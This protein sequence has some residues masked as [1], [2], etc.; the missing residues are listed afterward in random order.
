MC[1]YFKNSNLWR[2]CTLRHFSNL[3]QFGPIFYKVE[4][5]TEK[6]FKLFFELMAVLCKKNR[7][8]AVKLLF[9]RVTALQNYLS[10]LIWKLKR[11]AHIG[12]FL[13]D[14]PKYIREVACLP[15]IFACDQ[16]IFEMEIFLSE[17]IRKY[18]YIQKKYSRVRP[19]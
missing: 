14:S 12:Y 4:F 7:I 18:S 9:E 1:P 3:W 15:N 8:C 19:A 13:R 6:Q 10:R 17:N 11:R 2:K 16:N 5:V